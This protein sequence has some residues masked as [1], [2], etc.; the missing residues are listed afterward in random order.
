M[1]DQ[2]D[3]IITFTVRRHWW[4]RPVFW[5]GVAA[6]SVGLLNDDR[7][8]RFAT[9]LAEKAMYLQVNRPANRSAESKIPNA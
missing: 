7:L 2:L 4:F 1:A 8:T 6:A 9:W 3:V 5:L